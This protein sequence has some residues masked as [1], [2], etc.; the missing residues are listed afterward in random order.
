M[1]APAKRIDQHRNVIEAA[2]IVHSS[3]QGAEENAAFS[4]IIRSNRQ[5]EED[6]RNSGLQCVIGRNSIYIAPDVECL[7]TYKQR[8]EIANC[9]GDGKCG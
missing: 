5:T 2:K 6:V 9:A 7:E 8:G 3:V 1:D 4:S